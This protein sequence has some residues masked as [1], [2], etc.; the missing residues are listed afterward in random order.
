MMKER[1]EGRELF[2]P[3]LTTGLKL[4]GRELVDCRVRFVL[5]D[6]DPARHDKR[7]ILVYHASPGDGPMRIVDFVSDKAA[8]KAVLAQL[9]SVQS[10]IRFCRWYVANY[11]GSIEA[12]REVVA[13]NEHGAIT[14][15]IDR[16]PVA[17]IDF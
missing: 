15:V 2:V 16:K 3:V 6:K 12:V 4:S 7:G 5:G 11:D 8:G 1:F 14:K 9:D 17:G 10:A 13:R